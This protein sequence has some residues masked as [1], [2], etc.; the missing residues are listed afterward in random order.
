MQSIRGGGGRKT[1]VA[2]KFTRV[3]SCPPPWLAVVYPWRPKERKG[4]R[5]E[6]EKKKEGG[7]EGKKVKHGR[8]VGRK[9]GRKDGVWCCLPGGGWG[10]RKQMYNT[11]IKCLPP[12]TIVATTPSP[13]SPPSSHHSEEPK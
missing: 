5:E 8:K 9:E 11:V 7:K 3:G 6:A 12:S 10:E 13:P 1:K 2:V 4:L